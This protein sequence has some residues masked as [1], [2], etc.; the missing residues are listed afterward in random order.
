DCGERIERMGPAPASHALGPS[1]ARAADADPQ[2][3]RQRGGR[4]H[5]LADGVGVAHIR[6]YERDTRTELLG[7][8]SATVLIQIGDYD[9]GAVRVQP[10]HG[11]LAET[12]R[13][14]GDERASACYSHLAASDNANSSSGSVNQESSRSPAAAKS[15]SSRSRVNFA[16]ISVRSSSPAANS[17]R[18]PRS[19]IST[20]HGRRA[21]SRISTHSW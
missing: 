18:R 6:A 4:R 1:D 20:L 11:R 5:C 9:A 3:T 13:A 12:G 10:P 19:E 14:A 17:T 7:K 21:R 8:R 15:A 2:P 16:L